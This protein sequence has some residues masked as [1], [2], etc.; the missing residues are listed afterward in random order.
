M[1]TLIVLLAISSPLAAQEYV[2]KASKIVGTYKPAKS[3]HSPKSMVATAKAFLETLDDAGR[4]KV[5]SKLT[6]PKRREWTNLPA[7]PDADGIR[8]GDLNEKQIQAACDFMASLFSP[9]G[10][11]KVRNIMLADDQLLRNG[12]PR[13]GFGTENFSLVIFGEPS[14]EKPWGFQVDGHHVG[15]NLSI[16]GEKLTMSPSFIGTQ[17]D[18]FKIATTQFR[19]FAGETDDA[20]TILNSLTDEQKAKAV[21]ADRRG[22]IS[23]GPGADGK[24]AQAKGVSCSTFSA[25]QRKL[26]MSLIGQWVLDLPEKQAKARMQEL[27][28]EIDKMSFAWNGPTRPKSDISYYITGPTLIIEY[29]CQDL[30]GDPLAHLHSMYRNPTNEY[31]GQ[32]K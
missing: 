21:L 2:S 8:M 3:D 11:Q 13:P 15:V 17:P 16:E 24:S 25:E 14:T 7:R 4:A 5:L 20:Y 31:G 12:Q 28:K 27:E 22:R 19:P 23:F 10:Y 32:M 30:G 6:T 1:R 29:A 26:L 18:A 9:Q